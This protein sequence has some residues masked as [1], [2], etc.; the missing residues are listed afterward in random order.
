[1]ADQRVEI[2]DL[3]LADQRLPDRRICGRSFTPVGD[4]RSPWTRR[5]LGRANSFSELVGHE[6]LI[7]GQDPRQPRCF[8]SDLVSGQLATMNLHGFPD[9]HVRKQGGEDDHCGGDAVHLM[10]GL[11]LDFPR[12]AGAYATPEARQAD[13]R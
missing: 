9:C 13:L 12:T 3:H 6:V 1:M 4:R 5:T 10:I 11:A 7:K 8:E 2:N